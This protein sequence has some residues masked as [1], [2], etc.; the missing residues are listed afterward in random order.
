[1]QKHPKHIFQRPV[2]KKPHSGNYIKKLCLEN[3]IRK[4]HTKTFSK[5]LYPKKLSP[6]TCVQRSH[7]KQYSKTFQKVILGNYAEY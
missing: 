7:K 3:D 2:Y 6:R 1:M 4:L 5:K